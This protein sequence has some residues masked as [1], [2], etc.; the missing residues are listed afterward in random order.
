MALG[1]LALY[2]LI[3]CSPQALLSSLE[4]V[5]DFKFSIYILSLI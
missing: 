2:G 3:V 5:S 1:P 4:A